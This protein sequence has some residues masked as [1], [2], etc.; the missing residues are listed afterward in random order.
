MAL[1]TKITISLVLICGYFSLVGQQNAIDVFK[2]NLEAISQRLVRGQDEKDLQLIA[3]AFYER[4]K[5]NFDQNVNTEDVI[6]DLIESAKLYRYLQN[7]NDYYRSRILLGSSYVREEI[8]LEEA[9][10]IIAEA[11]RHF[12][13]N[14]MTA[15]EIEALIQMGLVHKNRLDYDKAISYVDKSLQRCIETNDHK[16]ELHSR[17]LLVSLFYQL[18]NVEKVIEQGEI[19]LRLEQKY[20]LRNITAD[21]NYYMGMA[22]FKDKQE[23]RALAYFEEAHRHITEHSLMALE[24]NQSLAHIYSSQDSIALAYRYILAANDI[25][26][27][28]LNK[29]KFAS[30]NQTA[31]KYQTKQKDREIKELLEDYN[32]IDVKLTQRT[33]FLFLVIGILA[34]GIFSAFNYYRLQQ[35]R[36]EIEK[37]IADQREEIANQKIIDLENALKIK[38]LESMVSGQEAERTRIATELH[39]SLGGL[40]SALKLQYD[41]LQLDHLPLSTDSNY[42]KILALIDEACHDVRDIS[43]NLK[44][45]ALE[46]LGL[47]AALKDLVNRYT[48]RGKLEINLITNNVDGLLNDDAKLHVFR[49]VQ[50]LLTNAVKHAEAS[51]IDIQINHTNDELMIL[52]EDNGKGFNPEVITRG[53]GL[54]NLESRINVLNGHMEIDSR[55][56]EGTSTIITIPLID[57]A[58]SIIRASV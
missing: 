39:D 45:I 56:N 41:T 4:A 32:Y 6:S 3:D 23:Q 8:F 46:K 22:L 12:I 28:L 34:L 58:K 57:K 13:E 33:R 55:L 16:N 24:I 50:E 15:N 21:I 47:S 42:H 53:L 31:A 35:H 5:L 19:T 49:I 27:Q 40:L 38:S 52:L 14:G 44:P 2:E 18:G 30:A 7:F 25:N 51:E 1:I 48:T 10:E 36:Y 37:L 43:R 17:L 11:Y 29:K 20:E 26:A 9:L 54:G